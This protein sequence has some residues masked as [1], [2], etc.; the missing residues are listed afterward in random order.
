M[1]LGKF[2]GLPSG[3]SYG[4]ATNWTYIDNG[5]FVAVF[6]AK[7]DPLDPDVK[8]EF[9]WVVEYKDGREVLIKHNAPLHTPIFGLDEREWCDFKHEILPVVDKFIETLAK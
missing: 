1:N 5:D 2:E 4:T 6:F 9:T 8:D 3:K 7:G